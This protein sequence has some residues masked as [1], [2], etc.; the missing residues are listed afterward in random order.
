MSSKNITLEKII[1]DDRQIKVL[2]QLLKN[3]KH[4]ISNTSL[5][6][7]NAHVK[8][9]KNHPYRAWYLI[10]SNENYIGSTYVME[11]NCIG[12][13]LIFDIS[14]FSQVVE[15]ISKKYKPLKEIKSVRPSNF[16][17]NVAPNNKKIVSQLNKLGAK[18]IQSTYTLPSTENSFLK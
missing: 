3:R 6:T 1:G 2:F 10:K 18:K 8:F 17:I 4:N 11:N 16:Y 13:S 7:T 15:L 9:V 12:V 14:N 5:P